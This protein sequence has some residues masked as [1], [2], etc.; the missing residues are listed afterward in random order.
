MIIVLGIVLIWGVLFRAD[1]L[2]NDPPPANSDTPT[3]NIPVQ[4]DVVELDFPK[5]GSVVKSPLTI[6]GRARG[7]WYFEATFP[8]E[9]TD[10]NG[11]QLGQHYAEAQS[12]WMTVE[13]VPFTSKITFKSSS[14]EN[15]FLILHKDNP[16]GLPENDRKISYPIKFR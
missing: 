4:G 2:K 10:A 1:Y 14:T 5:L 6:S 7:Y 9:I 15:G 11:N 16:S 13:L 3:K 8:V 12:D